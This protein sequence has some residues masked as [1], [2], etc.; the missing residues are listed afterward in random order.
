MKKKIALLLVI[1]LSLAF[2]PVFA[3]DENFNAGDELK[4]DQAI[5]ATSFSAG[6]SI[7]MTSEVDGM[8]FVAGNTLALSS[9]QDHLFAAGNLID[10]ENVKT[11]DAFLAASTIKIKSSEIRDL[12][13]AAETIRL[14]SDVRNAYLGG[15]KVTIN[16]KIDGDARISAEEIVLGDNAQITGTLKYPETCKVDISKS[17]LVNN[18][19]AYEVEKVDEGNEL[20][21]NIK[22]K[23]Y[24]CLSMILI[25]LILLALNSK[26]FAKIEKLD[27]KAGSVFKNM[28]IGLLVLVAT[29]ILAL[30][31]MITIVGFPLAIVSLI[32][33]GLLIYLSVIPTAYYFGKML[34]KKQITNNYLLLALSIAVIYILRMIPVIGGLVTFISLITGLGIYLVLIKN[35]IN[36]K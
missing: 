1:V 34:L 28:G 24:A 11:K 33:Y 23:I 2:I 32:C 9:T 31:A 8:N 15:T 30:I 7:D 29:P 6:N 3:K 18:K 27:K 21:D 5:G 12:Y 14:E 13:A 20:V 26:L 36:A 16:S 25:A 35:N 4:L 10:L 22:A 19:E 17:A